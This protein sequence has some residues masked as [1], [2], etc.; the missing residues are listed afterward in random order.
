MRSF[1]FFWCPLDSCSPDPRS[2]RGGQRQVDLSAI[3]PSFT[4]QTHEEDNEEEKDYDHTESIINNNTP[5]N[6]KT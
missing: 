2:D 3:F 5:R 1:C 6:S 4:V